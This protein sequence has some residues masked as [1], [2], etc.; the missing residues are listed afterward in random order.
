M[1]IESH[2]GIILTEKTRKTL[3]KLYPSGNMSATNL[4]WSEPGTNPGLRGERQVTTRLS[5]DTASILILRTYA[6]E[7]T[8]YIL[9]CTARMRTFRKIL[10]FFREGGVGLVPKHGC[11]LTLAYYAFPRWYEFGEQRWNDILT[12]ENRRTRRKTCP[13]ATL[14]TTNSTWIDPGANPG[15]RGERPATNDLSHRTAIIKV[16]EIFLETDMGFYYTD[17]FVSIGQEITNTIYNFIRV[18]VCF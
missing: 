9:K 14:S 6:R 16:T 15:L 4:T 12:G 13:S 11:L 8:P 3:R 5:H 1:S 18:H 10:S 7:C 17:Y 2:G